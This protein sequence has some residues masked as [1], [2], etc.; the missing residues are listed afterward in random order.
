[1]LE[2]QR[3][4]FQIFPIN[5]FIEKNFLSDDHC[6]LILDVIENE[7]KSDHKLLEGDAASS[8]S[9]NSNY[10]ILQKMPRSINDIQN[11]IQERIDYFTEIARIHPCQISYSWFNVQNEDSQ[12]HMH[13][14]GFSVVSGALYINTDELSST[15]D[16]INPNY[17]IFM[18]SSIDENSFILSN[19]VERGSLVIFPSYLAHGNWN[20]QNK[21]KNRVVISFNTHLK[22]F[23]RIENKNVK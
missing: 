11:K 18:G 14:H 7:V 22:K 17:S 6:D 13:A 21:S 5:I 10:G 15:L 1:M 4:I 20:S 2:V 3:N 23:N 16:F 8:Y 9:L 12:L 19:K